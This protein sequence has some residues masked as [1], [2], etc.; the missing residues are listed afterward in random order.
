MTSGLLYR[1]YLVRSHCWV[2]FVTFILNNLYDWLK[3][4]FEQIISIDAIQKI[5]FEIKIN[6]SMKFYFI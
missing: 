6:N 5:H 2:I 1:K 4:V 3:Y